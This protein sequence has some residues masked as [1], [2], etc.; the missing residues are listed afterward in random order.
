MSIKPVPASMPKPS[1]LN[2]K[3]FIWSTDLK[4]LKDFATVVA[5][6]PLSSQSQE[7]VDIIPAACVYG[8]MARYRAL[9]MAGASPRSEW[10]ERYR[11]RDVVLN[12]HIKRTPSL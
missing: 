3:V 10:V 9:R 6:A 5:L 4:D 12:L 1:I 8:F 2:S 11:Q 7:S